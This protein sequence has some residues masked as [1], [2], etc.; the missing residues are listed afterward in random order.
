M[1][2]TW[3][4]MSI[5]VC[6]CVV[7][8]LLTSAGVAHAQTTALYFDS[9]PGDFIGHN[10][11]DDIAQRVERT[12]LPSDGA[13][14]IST[15]TTSAPNYIRL[16]VIGPSFSFWWY[17][18]F[19]N[20]NGA[21][22]TVGSYG[23]VQAYPTAA[24]PGLSVTGSGRGC[25]HVR[26]R[27]RIRELVM[28]AGNAISA[29][30]ADFEQHCGDQAHA[31]YGAIRYNSSVSD[32]VPF[33]GAYP[34]YQLDI[35]QDPHGRVTGDGIDCGAGQA[36]CTLAPSAVTEATLTATPEPGYVFTGWR[37][38][39]R[40]LPTTTVRINTIKA[41]TALFESFAS[42]TSRSM[43]RWWSEPGDV[44]GGGEEL[45]LSPPNSDWRVYSRENGH[46]VHFMI[47]DEF[48]IPVWTLRLRT[49]KSSFPA[50]TTPRVT[51]P[52]RRST[53]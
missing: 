32:M 27:F 23:S 22:L 52:S 37:G 3:R 11:S 51:I 21:P 34:V 19:S 24:N 20:A 41:C 16:T 28:G 9:H 5:R 10:P 12:Y 50:P 1:L 53:G 4:L 35:T 48:D 13:F 7:A 2:R 43:L 18:E 38:D 31:L 33:G 47:D 6:A 49:G 14:T 44:I 39:C 29:F 42:S 46:S 25:G 17:L 40:G 15:P 26:G 36:A 45:F 30:A 8:V